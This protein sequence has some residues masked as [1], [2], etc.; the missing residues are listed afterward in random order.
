[1]LYMVL[2]SLPRSSGSHRKIVN[3][4]IVSLV[5]L[6]KTWHKKPAVNKKPAGIFGD[7]W[8]ANKESGSFERKTWCET[9]PCS[10]LLDNLIFSFRGGGTYTTPTDLTPKQHDSWLI[11]QKPRRKHKKPTYYFFLGKAMVF[12]CPFSS[13]ALFLALH[14]T[15]LCGG[16]GGAL[17]GTGDRKS[18]PRKD[19]NWAS[20]DFALGSTG[21]VFFFFF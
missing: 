5:G 8:G 12:L 11:E 16:E 21:P 9:F 4:A 10:S 6:S 20:S 15:T 1:M 13:S 19:I 2:Y 14:R 17:A 3:G 18:E 7:P